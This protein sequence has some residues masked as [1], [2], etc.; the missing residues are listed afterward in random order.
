MSLPF[1]Y[2]SKYWQVS[3]GYSPKENLSF[4]LNF[5]NVFQFF[6]AIISF[7]FVSAYF[8]AFHVTFPLL[9]FIFIVIVNLFFDKYRI[10]YLIE[11]RILKRGLRFFLLSVLK[12]VINT[13][14]SLYFLIALNGGAAGRMSGAMLGV[15]ITSTVALFLFIK[16][17]KYHFSFKIKKDQ[18]IKALKYCFPLIIASYAY[19][20]IGNT[21]RLLLEGLGKTGEYGYYSIGLKIAGFAGTFFL[22][23][24]QS[25]EPDLYKF[26]SQK[27]YKQYTL[28]ALLLIGILASLCIIFIIFSK[29]IVSYLTSGRYTYASTY[30]NIFIIGIFFMQLGGFFDQL[31]QAFGA[32]K[33]VMWLNTLMGIFCVFAY[34]FMIQKYQFYGANITRV[35]TSVF[36]V[37]C[38]A[39]LFLIYIK[40]GKNGTS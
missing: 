3:E 29:P 4:I 26:I 25:F 10:Y 21:D 27:K 37:F 20:P 1:Y 9:P 33:Y 30:A 28:F 12:I 24:Y 22:A 2:L 6:S 35:I 23:L 40:K 13:C 15:V 11:C 38:G 34:Y 14:F 36:Y 5:L 18:L 8:N 16:E 31:F 7:L 19:Y 32:T 17:K 39:S